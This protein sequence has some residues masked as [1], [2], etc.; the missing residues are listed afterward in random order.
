MMILALDLDGTLFD[1]RHDITDAVNASR[2]S[3]DLPELTL[4]EVTA[5][6]GHGINVL[7]E[8]AFQDSMVDI[9][10]ARRR[11]MDYY[12]LH[13]TDKAEP[14]PGVLE[15]LPKL[16]ATLTVVSNK[17][18]VL[19]DA[20]LERH[21][22]TD[23]FDFVAGGDTFPRKKPDPAALCFLLERYGVTRSEILVVGD[24]TPDIEMARS[25]GVRSVFCNYGFFGRDEVGADH[26]IDSFPELAGILEK[27]SG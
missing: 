18:K 7:A 17:P 21:A 9:A 20:L 22:I 2:Q 11:I 15:T 12:A 5:M 16:Q 27:C 3:F 10:L 24:H 25:A 8:K 14:Y 13:P 19:V 4:L 23:C 1:T 6:V 26:C